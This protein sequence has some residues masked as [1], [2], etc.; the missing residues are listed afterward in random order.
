MKKIH[1]VTALLILYA[2]K[3]NAA[4]QPTV[5]VYGGTPGGISAAIA[6]A[7]QGA[8][9]ILVEQTRHVGG[10][11]TSGIGTAETEHMIEE[12]ISGIPLEIYTRIGKAYGMNKPAFYF[13]SHVA[14][15]IFV[16]MLTEQHVSVIYEA[17]VNKVIKRDDVIKSIILTNGKTVSGDT[18]IDAT[19]EGDLMARAGV[20]YT[21]GRESKAQYDESLA[22]VR[23]LDKPID[24]SPYDDNGNLLPGFVEAKNLT[25]GEASKRIINYNFRLIMSTNSDRVPFPLP[26]HYDANRF[27]TLKHLLAEHPNT[28]LS[29]IIDL[30]SWNYPPGKFEAN[31]KQNSVISLG[32]FGGNTDYPDADYKKRKRIFQDHK[33]WTLGLLY[34]LEH[35]QSVPKPLHD[36]INRYG[37]AP[38][39]FMDNYNFPYYLY[40]REARRMV[41]SYVQTQKDIFEE[42][43][44]T[45]AIALGSHFVD[46]HHVQ[47]VAI[48]KT[49]YINEGR[50]WVK[51]DQ[52]YELSYGII[53]PRKS[54]CTNLLVPVCVSA[55]HVGFC[56]IRVEVTWMQLGE[57]AGVAAIIAAKNNKPV[58]DIDLKQ[59]QRVLKKDGVILNRDEKHWINNDK[60]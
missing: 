55:S 7:R 52:P 33:D 1:I 38:D 13:E 14:E 23:L 36:E 8:K 53:T 35:D 4:D 57:A 49:Q 60:S 2:F 41:G 25:N 43:K 54:E 15:K 40:I 48:S 44:K 45:D 5:V 9:V 42:P 19:Y 22:G 34:F 11:N 12:T 46:C 31:N 10:M 21:Y 28:K 17:F 29:D 59:L 56:S 26:S 24:V 39:E 58:Q 32:F 6:A 3:L 27:I 18:F 47:K 20:S 30:Y 51:V 50:I 37:L 16:D